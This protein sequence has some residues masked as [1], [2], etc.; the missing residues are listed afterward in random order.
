VLFTY[1]E[2][3]DWTGVTNTLK[4]VKVDEMTQAATTKAE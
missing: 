3:I 4:V 1:W 2:P